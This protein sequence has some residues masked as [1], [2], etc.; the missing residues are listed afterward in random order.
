MKTAL[1]LMLG[2]CMAVQGMAQPAAK[3]AGIQAFVSNSVLPQNAWVVS[4]KAADLAFFLAATDKR[5]ILRRLSAT[6]FILSADPRLSASL[7]SAVLF[8]APANYHW[9]LSPR[10]LEC[11]PALEAD[12]R[13]LHRFYISGKAALPMPCVANTKELATGHTA[14]NPLLLQASWAFIADHFLADSAVSFIDMADTPAKEEL[15]ITGFDNSLNKINLV[16]HDFPLLN[17]SSTVV[18]VKENRPDTAD[19]D[20]KPRL[21]IGK[22]ANATLS[23]HASTMATII[24]GAGNSYYTAGGVAPL[25]QISS[26]SFAVLLPDSDNYYRQNSVSVQNHSYGTGIENF[27][28]A[29]AAAYDASV[30]NNPSLVH[31]FSAGNAGNQISASGPYAGISGFANMT[32]SFKMAKNIITAGAADST[33][34]IALLSSRGP[35]YDG[36]VAPSLVAFGEDGSSGAAALVSGTALLLQQAYRQ[37]HGDTLPDAALVKTL[38]LNSA[39]SMTTGGIDFSSGYGQLDAQA[40]VSAMHTQQYFTG[41]MAAAQTRQFTLALPVGVNVLKIMLGWTD[42]PAAPNSFT[43]LVNNLDLMVK[44]TATDQQWLPWVLNSSPQKDSLPLPALRGIDS[45]NT[46]EQVTIHQ[47]PGGQYTVNVTARAIPAGVQRFYIAYQWDSLQTFRWTFPT[48][49]DNLL[50]SKQQMVRWQTNDSVNATLQYKFAG[51]NNWQTISTS[52]ATANGYAQWKTPDTS[53]VVQLRMNINGRLNTSDSFTISRPLQPAVGYNCADTALIFWN[54]Q[55][56]VPHYRFYALG[57]RT[58][59]AQQ[60]LTDTAFFLD[61]NAIASNWVSVAPVLAFNRTGIRS[62]AINYNNQGVG[63]YVESFTADLAGNT[64]KLT[65]SL[66]SVFLID[67]IVIEKMTGGGNYQPLQVF[68]APLAL[69]YS[70]T[71]RTL[72]KGVNQ[73][74]LRIDLFTGQIIYSNPETVMYLAGNSYLVYPNPVTR[75]LPVTVTVAELGNQLLQLYNAVGQPVYTR[76][77]NDLSLQLPTHHLAPGLYIYHLSAGGKIV[78]RGKLVVQ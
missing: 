36:R 78:A 52:L 43:A 38:L 65:A 8:I 67:R 9:K 23:A 61:K 2:F 5:L 46:T 71:D 26:S 30:I 69:Q 11:L 19:I 51:S 64:V 39:G 50:P 48:G 47:P 72:R 17:G 21:L 60:T 77:M 55:N 49:D 10:L 33:G 42:P 20:L 75:P 44:H 73:Y 18:S 1:L 68:T 59:Q 58:M 14:G 41:T 13:M 66:G 15:S 57:N 74:R 54:R 76:K 53:A 28:G 31:V 24:A 7:L 4:I 6:S 3:H 35:A 34:R 37:Q 22:E 29:D 40:A 12:T 56:A 63:C 25:A 70:I 45:L 16:H 27:Y 62:T 32:G